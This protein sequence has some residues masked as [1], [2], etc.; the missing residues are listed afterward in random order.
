MPRAVYDAARTGV[1][2]R[3][4][5]PPQWPL[6]QRYHAGRPLPRRWVLPD[7]GRPAI[8]PGPN[9]FDITAAL[10]LLAEDA[11]ARCPHF[12]HIDPHRLLF[13]FTASRNRRQYGLLARV[14]PLRYRGGEPTRTVRGV[15]YGIQ[16]YHVYGREML[17]L[18]S[19]CLPRYFEQPFEQ[20][21]IT[22]FH[23]LYHIGERFDGDLRRHPGRYALHTHSK[24]EYDS[25]MAEWVREY[26]AGHPLPQ[27]FG[28]LRH[29]YADLWQAHGGIVGVVVPQPK[30][31]P[32][33]LQSKTVR[34][35][36]AVPRKRKS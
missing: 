19:F 3:M 20:K 2:P 23:E 29:R 18:V 1:A 21:L 6:E 24:A 14:T 34:E 33:V 10:R 13:T 8:P 12:A 36:A 35:L 22:L 4:S 15:P 28:F 7:A 26:L 16:R 9:P 31:I 5:F 11:V 27:V 17:Y 30:Q 32:L 25:K